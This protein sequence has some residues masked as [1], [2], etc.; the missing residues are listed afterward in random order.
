[1]IVTISGH[2]INNAAAAFGVLSRDFIELRPFVAYFS[3]SLLRGISQTKSDFICGIREHTIKVQAD[4]VTYQSEESVCGNTHKSWSQFDSLFIYV[5]PQRSY[6]G[7]GV[8]ALI[9]F[10]LFSFAL[11]LAALQTSFARPSIIY[12]V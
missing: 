2:D 6:H 4:D 10:L 1:M 9:F 5:A 11:Q 8:K 12:T 3:L 7:S